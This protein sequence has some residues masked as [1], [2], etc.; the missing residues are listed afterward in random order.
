M[1]LGNGLIVI[2]AHQSARNRPN[3]SLVVASINTS[4]TVG[5]VTK[6]QLCCVEHPFNVFLSAR[7]N[8][9][10]QTLENFP[11][12][13]GNIRAGIIA[14]SQR[15]QLVRRIHRYDTKFMVVV[16][17]CPRFANGDDAKVRV[18]K[19][20]PRK[21][22]RRESD[23]LQYL[24]PFQQNFAQLAMGGQGQERVWNDERQNA[25]VF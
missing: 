9:R 22:F 20:N 15:L 12:Q 6:T 10:I 5:D 16:G 21:K 11:L 2:P 18:S 14:T 24:S 13:D 17:Q 4:F 8:P 7:P 19:S 3:E 23:N 1:S 25:I